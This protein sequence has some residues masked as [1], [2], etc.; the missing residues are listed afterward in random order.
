MFFVD[1]CIYA[2]SAANGGYIL[3]GMKVTERVA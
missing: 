3:D 2:K 1:W